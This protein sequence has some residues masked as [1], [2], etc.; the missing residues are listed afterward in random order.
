MF[1]PTTFKALDDEISRNSD[2]ISNIDKVIFDVGVRGSALENLMD[3]RKYLLEQKAKHLPS[4]LQAGKNTTFNDRDAD[5]L[6]KEITSL[7]DQ[8]KTL[9]DK[10]KNNHRRLEVIAEE[11]TKE[12]L[13]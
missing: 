5:N 7:K 12:K 9:Y 13:E 3:E 4:S 6:H 10:S 8:V 11:N 1:T 2:N